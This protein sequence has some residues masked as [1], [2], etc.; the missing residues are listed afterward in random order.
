[1]DGAALLVPMATVE[2]GLSFSLGRTGL[3]VELMVTEHFIVSLSAG[4]HLLPVTNFA[5]ALMFGFG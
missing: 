3:F 2:G 4:V 1:M 5:L